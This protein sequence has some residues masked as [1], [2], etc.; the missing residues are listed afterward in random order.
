MTL[1][2]KRRNG[3]RIVVDG[4]AGHGAT[5]AF[6]V[7]GESYLPVLDA[8]FDVSAIRLV[9]CR[10]ESGAG[11]MAEAA[12]KL[13]GRP[14]IALVTR[15]PGACNASIAVHTAFQDS[16]PL[17][18]L[19]GQV[20]RRH[21]GREAFQELDYTKMFA[22]VAKA[23]FEAE[24]IERLPRLIG[25]AFETALSGRPGPVVVVLPED[26]LAETSDAF[27]RPPAAIDGAQPTPADLGRLRSL[28]RAAE[29]PLILVGGGG[30]SAE[31]SAACRS[32]AEA[33]HLPVCC[34]FRRLDAFANDSPSYIGELGI[35]PN[36]ALLERV[37]EADLLLVVGAR[38]GEITTQGYTLLEA[39]PRQ[40]LIH[41]HPNAEELGRVFRPAMAIQAGAASFA[42]AMAAL[43]VAAEPGWRNWTAAARADYLAWQQPAA[44][45]DPDVLDLG[46]IMVWLRQRLPPDAIVTTDAGN[47]SGWAQRFLRFGRPGRFLGATNGAM[48][49]GVPAAVAA[50]LVHPERLVLGMVG[51][52][53][54][55]MTGQELATARL[56]GAAPVI[57]V[58]DNGMFGTIRM[59]QER[60]FPGRV[61][62]T[63]LVN[64]D[65]A[66]L[67]QSYGAFGATVERT[68]QFAPGFEAAVASGRAAVL[69]LRLDPEAITTRTTLS[70]IRAE[71]L[72]RRAG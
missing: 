15:G 59:H 46:A 42:T 25:R 34:S 51:D 44:P 5:L 26:V 66:A 11:F 62:A 61:S 10:H 17:L 41:I 70:A 38:L 72:A 45:H 2:E 8:L 71:A 47:F 32:F 9:T 64:P 1:P 53:G 56:S 3:G 30:W 57:L 13:T 18:L 21:R 29:R 20:A 43:P 33:A 37:R 31:A 49:Y 39:P 36:P 67:A 65:F 40:T 68:E 6:C 12:A 50:K 69:A 4:L 23:V 22:P 16:T 63:D 27:D 19:V 54:F 35:G 55:L 28:L 52:G 58:F 48:G 14:G 7:P 60:R 24:D